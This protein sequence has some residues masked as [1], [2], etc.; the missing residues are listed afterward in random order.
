MEHRSDIFYPVYLL[1]DRLQKKG[2][3]GKK[4]K[5][6]RTIPPGHRPPLGRAGGCVHHTW[7]GGE[8]VVTYYISKHFLHID[9]RAG[10]ELQK[11]QSAEEFVKC[12]RNLLCVPQILFCCYTS[13]LQSPTPPYLLSQHLQLLMRLIQGCTCKQ[14]VSG[15][16][17]LAT[18]NTSGIHG[19]SAVVRET[20]R[21]GQAVCGF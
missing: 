12:R 21:V 18:M 10:N 6:M 9:T 3:R 14:R 4:K 20:L 17:G 1:V 11:R 7:G 16:S 15:T 2:D 13:L 19:Q 8:A 5:R